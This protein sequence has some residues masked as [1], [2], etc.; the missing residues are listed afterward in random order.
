MLEETYLFQF[1]AELSFFFESDV[2]EGCAVGTKVET[3]QL[4]DTFAAHD[5]AAEMADDVDDL[6]RIVL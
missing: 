5:V 6:L 4:H 3:Y 2:L 1:F